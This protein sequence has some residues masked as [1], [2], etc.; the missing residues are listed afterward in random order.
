M[1]FAVKSRAPEGQAIDVEAL[2]A[3]HAKRAS[4][5]QLT[6]KEQETVSTAANA[7]VDSLEFEGNGALATIFK[8][9]FTDGT[10]STA[11]QGKLYQA[12]SPVPDLPANPKLMEHLKALRA[13]GT[14][15]DAEIEHCKK[16][17]GK[18]S[19]AEDDA[20]YGTL[21]ALAVAGGVSPDAATS[22]SK[23][24]DDQRIDREKYAIGQT[25]NKALKRLGMTLGAVAALGAI[26]ALTPVGGALMILGGA[27]AMA[28]KFGIATG[29]VYG[30]L[31]ASEK[32][33]QVNDQRMREYGVKD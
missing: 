12:L 26:F 14:A 30:A 17:A 3:I 25:R 2:K 29:G 16:L 21:A 32:M 24:M 8:K 10:V 9:M 11:E 20:I 31:K 7:V 23:W 33:S 15:T 28:A 6:A 22:I 4:G 18:L 19:V 5:K 27:G 13:K 1:G